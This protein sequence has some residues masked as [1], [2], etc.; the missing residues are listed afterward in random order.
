MMPI[1]QSYNVENSNDLLALHIYYEK[2]MRNIN[3]KE[4]LPVLIYFKKCFL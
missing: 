3:L 4:K 1:G 2:I